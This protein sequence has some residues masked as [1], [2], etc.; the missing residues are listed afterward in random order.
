MK[1][2]R[3]IKNSEEIKRINP[4]KQFKYFKISIHLFLTLLLLV[5]GIGAILGNSMAFMDKNID[6]EYSNQG[7]YIPITK[8][9]KNIL[10]VLEPTQEN[11]KVVKAVSEY[12]KT[13]QNIQNTQCIL[14]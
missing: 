7:I 12:I 1:K 10:I 14:P 3:K 5:L 2:I 8:E 11:L 13:K 6:K 9:N 4:K